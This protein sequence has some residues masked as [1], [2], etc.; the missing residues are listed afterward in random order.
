MPQEK[1]IYVEWIDS[2]GCT[3]SWVRLDDYKPEL[4]I[5]KSIGWVIYEDDNILSICGNI[6]D[7]TST[8]LYQGNG[9]MTIPK[10]AIIATK[11]LSNNL[12]SL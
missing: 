5:H 6:A 4:P 1:L 2:Q 8:T 3:P 9:I 12:L 10:I 11:E 7:E